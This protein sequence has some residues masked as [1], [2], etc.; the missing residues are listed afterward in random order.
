MAMK[1]EKSCGFV[2]FRRTES[3]PEY[4]LLQNSSKFYWDFPKGLVGD[5]ESELEAAKRELEEEA[6]LKDIKII[7]GFKETVKY[8]YKF[9]DTTIDKTLIMFLAEALDDKV[10]VSWEHSRHEW[11]PFEVAKTRLKD[12][13]LLV[14]ERAHKFLSTRLGN[15]TKQP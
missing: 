10:T 8:V 9:K 15:W 13:K 5:G 2:V 7:S 14:I 6:G 12:K 4:L 1:K 3:G 11:V